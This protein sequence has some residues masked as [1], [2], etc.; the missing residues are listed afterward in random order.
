MVVVDTNILIDNLRTQGRSPIITK[1][2]D[3]YSTRDLY[4]SVITIHELF[5]GD[6]ADDE[7]AVLKIRKTLIP[8][9]IVPYG[10]QEAE[11][12]GKLIRDARKYGQILHVAD[13]AIAATAMFM[14]AELATI[15]TK[16]F[17]RIKGLK[18]VDFAELKPLK[19]ARI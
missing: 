7:D 15:N 16:D 9:T 1:L 8:F 17:Y 11:L 18:L 12:A 3:S 6:S 14:D 10:Q 5:A 4:V 2:S 19:Y 13:S